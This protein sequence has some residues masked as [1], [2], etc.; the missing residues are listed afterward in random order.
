MATPVP[1][2]IFQLVN[3]Q[4]DLVADTIFGDSQDSDN[5]IYADWDLDGNG[6][7]KMI[8]KEDAMLQTALKCVFTER[9]TNGYGSGVYDFIGVKDSGVRRLS[10]FMDV[11]FAILSLKGFMNAVS[12]SQNLSDYDKI[13]TMKSLKVLDSDDDPTMLKVSFTLESAEGSLVNVGVI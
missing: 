2:K 8:S 9:Q 11:T 1:K 10:I 6:N 13:V 3:L 12:V 7:I 4:G 5:P